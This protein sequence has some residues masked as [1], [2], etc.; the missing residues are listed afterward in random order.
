VVSLIQ[1]NS[2]QFNSIQFNSILSKE[3]VMQSSNLKGK[4]FVVIGGSAGI[5]LAVAQSAVNAGASVTIVGRDQERLNTAKANIG[6]SVDSYALDI[7]DEK[8]VAGFFAEIPQ[9]DHL[10]ITSH[11]TASF[12]GA[13]RPLETL[14]LQAAR[15]FMDTKFWGMVHAVKYGSLKLSEHGSITLFSGAASR[16]TVPN[17]TA[18]AAV[19]GAV[20]AFAKQAAKELAPRRVNVVSPGVVVTP[21]YD[22]IPE[23]KRNSMFEK[24]A[25]RLPVGRVGRPDEVGDAVVFLAASGYVTGALIDIDGGV[26]VQ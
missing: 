6:T 15:G 9:F 5:G 12:F 4:R 26:Q 19:N 8:A 2:I 16:R 17:H 24:T 13:L 10:V 1:F 3:I 23:E 18:I 11:S 7:T 20:E 14:E 22:V 21:A 25:Q